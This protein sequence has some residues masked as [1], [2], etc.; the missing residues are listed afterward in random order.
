[1]FNN[2]EFLQLEIISFVLVTLMFDSGVKLLREV[3]SMSL[4]G[5]CNISKCSL[6]PEG[7]QHKV[8]PHSQCRSPHTRSLS[9]IN[10]VPA[11]HNSLRSRKHYRVKG[12]KGLLLMD[13]VYALKT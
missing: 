5:V 3:K 2:Q 12:L 10:Q 7:K 4:L 9:H 13:D 8:P 1:M 11:L 6:S